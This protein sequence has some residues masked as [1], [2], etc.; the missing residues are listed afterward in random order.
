MARFPTPRI[1]VA[2][3]P[4]GDR[5]LGDRSFTPSTRILRKRHKQVGPQLS[6][7]AEF[8]LTPGVWWITLIVDDDLA[9]GDTLP[10]I[11]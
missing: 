4:R 6:N 2:K 9:C 8:F 11:L 7:E 3:S 10:S 1:Y 5:R